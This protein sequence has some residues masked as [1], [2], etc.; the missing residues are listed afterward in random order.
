VNTTD[1][2]IILGSR[3]LDSYQTIWTTSY[4]F[5]EL[6]SLSFRMR[7][8]WTRVKYVDYHLL[9]NEGELL[10]T[11]YSGLEEDGSSSH[12]VNFN[13]FNID[14]VYRWVFSPG[15]EIRVVWKNSILGSD[16]QLQYD[17]RDNI[18]ETFSYD[19]L[20]SFSLRVLYFLDYRSL[21]K[22]K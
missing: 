5:N 20:N 15:S 14:L 9:G 11:T 12:N 2:G 19:Q 10:E 8:Y 7:H 1:D 3:D 22:K 21:K 6:M 16:T 13:A 4:V 17:Y 18:R